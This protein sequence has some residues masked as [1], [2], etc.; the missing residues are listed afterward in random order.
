M[1]NENLP[2]VYNIREGNRS[3]VLPI[4]ECGWVFDEDDKVVGLAPVEN[5]GGGV[6][7]AHCG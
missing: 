3:I 1:S 5:F 6:V 2:P 4:L 7:G